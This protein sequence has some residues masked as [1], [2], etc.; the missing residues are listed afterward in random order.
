MFETDV[1]RETQDKTAYN[2]SNNGKIKIQISTDLWVEHTTFL[3]EMLNDK[4]SIN[5]ENF[6]VTT[7]LPSRLDVGPGNCQGLSNTCMS[8]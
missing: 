5:I 2:G 1:S 7:K 8:A 4:F 3:T 6:N